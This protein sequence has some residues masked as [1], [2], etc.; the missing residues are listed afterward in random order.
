MQHAWKLLSRRRCPQGGL[1]TV[2][3]GGPSSCQLAAGPARR[4]TSPPT[5]AASASCRASC[6]D[7]SCTSHPSAAPPHGRFAASASSWVNPGRRMLRLDAGAGQHIHKVSGCP[8]MP[9]VRRTQAGFETLSASRSG[10][11]GSGG[12]GFMRQGILPVACA[13]WRM[14]P[15]KKSEECGRHSATVPLTYA[16]SSQYQIWGGGGGGGVPAPT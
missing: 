16:G 15:S 7:P 13:K 4:R 6:S 10:C 1:T 12:G 14:N 11:G 5:P 3:A 9:A 8:V 2:S